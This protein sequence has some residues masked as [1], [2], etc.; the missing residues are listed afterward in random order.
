VGSNSRVRV[1]SKRGI[2][3]VDFVEGVGAVGCRLGI[4]G[5]RFQDCS[6]SWLQD[7]GSSCRFQDV[8]SDSSHCTV[9][10]APR[11]PNLDVSNE[12][13]HSSGANFH[14]LMYKFTNII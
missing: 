3:T 8:G 4:N 10:Q 14:Y 2:V 9:Q 13:H 11:L 5:H 7:W 12:D 6:T 1:R